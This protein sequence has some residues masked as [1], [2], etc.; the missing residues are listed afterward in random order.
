MKQRTSLFLPAISFLVG[1]LFA[2]MI[3]PTFVRADVSA[4]CVPQV[5]LPD[6]A[7]VES[8]ASVIAQP[9][10]TPEESITSALQAPPAVRFSELLPDPVGDDAQEFIELRNDGVADVALAGWKIADIK[11]HTFTIGDAHIAGNGYLTFLYAESKIRLTNT[12]ASY[13]LASPDGRVVDLAQYPTPVP[14]GKS[15]AILENGW[16]W[17]SVLTPGAQ[18]APDAAVPVVVAPVLPPVASVPVAPVAPAPVVVTVASIIPASATAPAPTATPTFSALL[19]NPSDNAVNEWME[20]TNNSS[21][22]LALDGWTVVDA[23]QKIASLK[24]VT[25]IAGETI[26]LPKSIT[27]ITLNND[28]E[29]VRILDPAGVMRDDV[30]YTNAPSGGVYRKEGDIWV[31]STAP[32]T[33]TLASATIAENGSSDPG[34]TT[35]GPDEVQIAEIDGME[36]ATPI[37]FSGIVTLPPGVLGKMTF[38][39]MDPSGGAATFVRIRAGGAAPALKKGDLVRIAGKKSSSAAY[40]VAAAWQDVHVLGKG[41]AMHP[42]EKN[43]LEIGPEDAGLEVRLRGVVSGRG[44]RWISLTDETAEREVRVTFAGSDAPPAKQGDGAVVTGVV[45]FKNDVAGLLA[46]ERSAATVTPAVAATPAQPASEPPP[47]Q[48]S[49]AQTLVLA[50]QA[51]KPVIGYAA[52]GMT[53]ALGI[54]GYVLWKRRRYAVFD[55]ESLTDHA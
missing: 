44:K 28:T 50:A 24:G 32:T 5:A 53:A 20:I 1:G 23:A 6:A 54:V 9:T 27:K 8:T 13:T 35:S 51:E 21:S 40:G 38:A 26:R 48:K 39:V 43:P 37:T 42:I 55:E 25:I 46:V 30:R 49:V 47:Q 52:L 45:R 4:P 34:A 3:A 14:Q 18:N 17:T 7:T 31:W 15:Y 33:S 16:R 12:G 2:P 19:P 11:G 41:S 36:S 10:H 29:E 22:T